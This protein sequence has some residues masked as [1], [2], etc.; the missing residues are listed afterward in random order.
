MDIITNPDGTVTCGPFTWDVRISD[1]DR[2]RETWMLQ[3]PAPGM[4]VFYVKNYG[5]DPDPKTA[6]S[7]WRVGSGGPFT[8]WGGW[9][10]RDD[11]LRGATPKLIEYYLKEIDEEFR[12]ATARQKAMQDLLNN[13]TSKP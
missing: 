7:G 9:T 2:D 8:S 6:F 12:R 5:G 3:L 13:I 11:A 1:K 10:S 4:T